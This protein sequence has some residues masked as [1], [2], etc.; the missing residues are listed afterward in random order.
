MY[1]PFSL[2]SEVGPGSRAVRGTGSGARGWGTDG[3]A[4][5]V[6][7]APSET[8]AGRASKVTRN[9]GKCIG[10]VV[11]VD[12]VGIVWGDTESAVAFV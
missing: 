12:A 6:S 7:G 9:D 5:L 2:Y 11:M 8:G 1:G 10:D 3:R 4:L